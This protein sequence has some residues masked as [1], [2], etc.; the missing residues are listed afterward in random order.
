MTLVSGCGLGPY[1][2][3]TG[4]GFGSKGSSSVF[5][6]VAALLSKMAY[7]RALSLA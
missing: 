5:T 7:R 6:A 1:S 4:G 3:Y 2:E